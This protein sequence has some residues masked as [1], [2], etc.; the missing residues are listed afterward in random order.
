M[1]C[2]SIAGSGPS[3]ENWPHKVTV[4]TKKRPVDSEYIAVSAHTHLTR[5][6]DTTY[7]EDRPSLIF[8]NWPGKQTIGD[9]WW[10]AHC[11]DWLNYFKSFGSKFPKP[12]A[13]TLAVY[14]AFERWNPERI[15][16]IGMDWVLDGNPDWFHDAEAELKSIK[17]LGVE[18]VDLRDGST[19]S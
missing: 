6:R 9:R 14:M 17:G 12:S 5:W 18:L 10:S 7:N 4:T 8:R 13:G 11:N 3:A 16:L 1:P 19:I 2:V 15:E